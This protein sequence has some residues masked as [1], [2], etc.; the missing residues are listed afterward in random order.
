MKPVERIRE[1]VDVKELLNV[2]GAQ[3]IKGSGNVRSCC[4]IHQGDNPSA[5]VFSEK[6]KLWYCH[7]G[8]MRGGDV[9][10]FVME[11]EECTFMEAVKKLADLFKVKV[12]WE[13]EEIE[14]NQFR[15]QAKAFIERMMKKKNVHVLPAFK[16]PPMKLAKIKEYRGYSPETIEAWKLRM[17][18]EGELKDRIVIA[19]ED[20]DRRLVGITGRATLAEQKEKFLH[21]PRNLHTGYFLTGLG[22]NLEHVKHAGNRVK[23]VEG[24]FDACRW[25]EAGFKNVCAPIGLFFT[26]EHV[27]QLYKAGVT[28]LEFGFDNDKAGRNGIR[29]AI[30]KARG[31][32]DIY[33]LEYEQ[34]K[35]ADDHTPEELVQVDQ[36]KLSIWEWYEKYGEELEK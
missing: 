27:L 18:V 16:L 9:Y 22:R 8:C 26:D 25:Y 6:E 29:K 33:V 7:T 36:N 35:D 21:R 28:I 15:E 1:A 32:F 13:N 4:P 31:K 17:C 24:V 3:R 5:F 14:E 10:D 2:Y 12:D 11:M 23:I 20:V 34:G 19:F 30:K